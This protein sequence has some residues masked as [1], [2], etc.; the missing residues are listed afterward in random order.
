M[1]TSV[2]LLTSSRALGRPR[3][4]PTDLRRQEVR[5]VGSRL[6]SATRSEQRVDASTERR[7]GYEPRTVRILVPIL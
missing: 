7:V 3:Q 1:L 6:A 2:L 5:G 4:P